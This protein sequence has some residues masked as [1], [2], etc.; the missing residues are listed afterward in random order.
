MQW[1]AAE[2]GNTS[3]LIWLGKQYIGQKDKAESTVS[4]EHVHAY[5]WLSDDS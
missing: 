3:I 4:G 1:Q 5:K 2:G